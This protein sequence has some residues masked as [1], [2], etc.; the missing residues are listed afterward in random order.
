MIWSFWWPAHTIKLSRSSH[1][2]KKHFHH[3][4]NSKAF[5]SFLYISSHWFHQKDLIELG[6]WSVG[7]ENTSW[8][9]VYPHWEDMFSLIKSQCCHEGVQVFSYHSKIEVWLTNWL[10]IPSIWWPSNTDA[11]V[12]SVK[13]SHVFKKDIGCL[14]CGPVKTLS[15]DLW[16][17][18]TVVWGKQSYYICWYVVTLLPTKSVPELVIDPVNF[19]KW[20]NTKS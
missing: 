5:R 17:G 14:I 15:A 6:P 9:L 16:G 8:D 19:V 20:T 13:W 18:G 11:D 2:T 7:H 12:V 4:G 1:Y 3:A 10:C